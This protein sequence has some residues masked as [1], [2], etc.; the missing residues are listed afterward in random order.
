[1]KHVTLHIT[2]VL[3]RASGDRRTT[4]LQ[5][6]KYVSI[7]AARILEHSALALIQARDCR[8]L[9]NVYNTFHGLLRLL[10]LLSFQ[11]QGQVRS[12]LNTVTP[13]Q[14]R[15]APRTWASRSRRSGVITSAKASSK[16]GVYSPGS[17]DLRGLL[18][19]KGCVSK[20]KAPGEVVVLGA[21]EGQP[22]E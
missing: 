22:P 1:M 5:H 11:R 7:D 15:S 2:L 21:I 12:D 3:F 4:M 20:H 8:P 9:K 18:W 17:H 10:H 19:Q 16:A 14:Q 13:F 6:W